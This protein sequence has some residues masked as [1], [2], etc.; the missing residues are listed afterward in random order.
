[1]EW[2]VLA[3]HGQFGAGRG[4]E[5]LGLPG[6][7]LM[8]DI[9]LVVAIPLDYLLAYFSAPIK[10]KETYGSSPITQLS[11]PGGPGGM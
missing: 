1:M 6:R 9:T 4:F 11:W 8:G 2:H 7:A 3:P 10:C 5:F